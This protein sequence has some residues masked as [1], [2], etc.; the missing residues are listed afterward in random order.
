MLNTINHRTVNRF[1]VAGPRQITGRNIAHSVRSA[2]QRAV[3][4]AELLEGSTVLIKPTL[5]QAAEVVGVCAA[6]VRAARQM[7]P[8]ERIGVI[9]GTRSL[10][11]PRVITLP[12][13]VTD[14]E[15]D[16]L[17]HLDGGARLWAALERAES[18][19]RGRQE[20]KFLSAA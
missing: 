16:R 9:A 13:P 18:S 11:E 20:E 1:G 4:G 10:L 19:A 15:L 5:L 12:S 7:S 6:Y 2:Q 17:A 14:T 8:A 3:L